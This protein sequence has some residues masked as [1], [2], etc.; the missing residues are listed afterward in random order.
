[1]SDGKWVP[2]KKSIEQIKIKGG[3]IFYDTVVYTH[4]GPVVYDETFHSETKPLST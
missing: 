3:D 2:T 1:L 4:H